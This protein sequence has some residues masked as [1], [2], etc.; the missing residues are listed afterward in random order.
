MSILVPA[1]NP[2]TEKSYVVGRL[3]YLLTSCWYGADETIKILLKKIIWHFFIAKLD[4][5]NK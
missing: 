4:L 2:L 3:P 5:N 1:V